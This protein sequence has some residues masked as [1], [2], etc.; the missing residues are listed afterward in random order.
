MQGPAVLTILQ[1]SQKKEKKEKQLTVQE[2]A[3]KLC[4]MLL[5]AHGTEG[6]P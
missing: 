3:V 5:E 4:Y 1:T 2:L 6:R